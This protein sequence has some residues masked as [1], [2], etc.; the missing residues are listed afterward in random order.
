MGVWRHKPQ[1]G[2][3]SQSDL[4]FTVG[5]SRQA[6]IA[7][8]NA[9]LF[10][11][12]E[13]QKEYFEALFINNPAAIVTVDLDGTVMS[14]SPAAERLFGY[15]QEE[16]I[17][18]EVDELVAIED[19]LQDEARSYT[20]RMT[21]LG[22][23][24]I[25]ARRNRKDGSYVDVEV[26]GLPV[27]V[28]GEQ[29]GYVV[30]YHDISE[31]EKARRAAEQA[32]QAK[33]TFLANM[34]H[35]LRT[36][37]NAIIGFTR[38]VKRKGSEILPEKQLD[39]LDKVL[40]SGEH[41]L[42]LINTVLDIAKIEAGRV[43]VTAA[44]FDIEPLLDIVL[45]TAQPLVD[46]KKV[47]LEKSIQTD[48]GSI[49]ND[50]EKIKQILINLLSNA[51]KFTRQGSITI[52]A[53]RKG[54]DLS[55]AVSDTG[56]G[57]PAD[58]L[59]SIFEEF[60]QAD[61]STTREYG[62]TGLGLSIS[63]SLARLLG[64]DLT[65]KSKMG[66]GS[67]FTLM[68]PCRYGEQ[69]D[70]V[71]EDTETTIVPARKLEKGKPVVLVIDDNLD[72]VH[73][74]EQNLEESGY[75]VVG[76]LNGDEGV[77]LAR[78]HKPFAITLDIMMPHKDGWQVLHELKTNPETR[79]IPVIMISIVDKKAMGYRLGASDYLVKPLEEGAVLAALERLA[80]SN[81]GVPPKRVLV[82]DDDP[83]IVDM[84]SQLL[85]DSQ[86]AVESAPDGQIALK[87]IEQQQP[88]A[89]LLDLLMPRLDGFGVLEK[90]QE[91]KSYR[92]I[93]VIVLTAKSLTAKETA[94]LEKRVSRIIQKQ[95]LEGRALIREL[96]KA[97]AA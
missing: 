90:L 42:G 1:P 82:V 49:Y 58:K 94:V 48:L 33:S 7:I 91:N 17:G 35:E 20:K 3:F 40:V 64:G 25:T 75:Q 66:K 24:Q 41:L 23:V 56:I 18:Q 65:V 71:S 92:H 14:W 11:E 44:R 47:R 80:H 81:G 86:Y 13:R 53:S 4:D 78:R 74:L 93:P 38:I 68:V 70:M 5:L 63:R 97:V 73:L 15:T 37:L 19:E 26:L 87:L 55:L 31:I 12:V 43:E 60:Q 45:T 39:N 57:I 88:D 54:D 69:P 28:G 22:R 34:S 61:T 9:R 51:A 52:K 10:E 84:V 32:N 46:Q 72:V 62:G 76:A 59:G 95:G 29:I 6:A 36:P 16:A 50:Q 89:I 67:I 83:Q 30:I 85:E 27:I 77:E 2:P 21:S 96:Q 8:Q 79:D